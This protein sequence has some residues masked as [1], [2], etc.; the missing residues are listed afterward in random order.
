MPSPTPAW[1]S[2]SILPIPKHSSTV[3]SVF[4][5]SRNSC[6]ASNAASWGQIIFAIVVESAPTASVVW[7]SEILAAN[8]E[9][10]GSISG[11]TIFSV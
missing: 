6:S 7:W 8:T 3:S 1:S 10:P 2:L 11:A 4:A 9:D 5:T